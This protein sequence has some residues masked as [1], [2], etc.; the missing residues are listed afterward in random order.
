MSFDSLPQSYLTG[1]MSPG[2]T[3]YLRLSLGCIV[4]RVASAYHVAFP[5]VESN[6]ISVTILVLSS[7]SRSNILKYFARKR[8]PFLSSFI[9]LRCTRDNVA[10]AFCRFCDSVFDPELFDVP[11]EA[12]FLNERNEGL[13]RQVKR[14][15]AQEGD[16]N[17]SKSV[18]AFLRSQAEWLCVVTASSSTR[19]ICVGLVIF[20]F[21]C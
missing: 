20:Y 19:P 3:S 9:S 14:F 13:H 8:Y 5:T 11:V 17:R 21:S 16:L 12:S 10:A 4:A 6:F 18:R 2:S 15:Q 1:A 7:L